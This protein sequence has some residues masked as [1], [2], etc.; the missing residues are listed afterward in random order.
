M[1]ILE[2]PVCFF[3]NFLLLLF[4][5]IFILFWTM[6][7]KIW[8][9]IIK[10]FNFFFS[11][12]IWMIVYLL[13]HKNVPKLKEKSHFH[14]CFLYPCFVLTH[15]SKKLNSSYYL[16]YWKTTKSSKIESKLK[17]PHYKSLYCNYLEKITWLN[18][19]KLKSCGTL[20]NGEMAQ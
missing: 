18:T 3:F 7:Y 15:K 2:Q 16:M 11:F 20:G 10:E 8:Q 17:E 14:F 12:F 5:L 9:Q 13:R 4:C 6:G 19:S 1:G